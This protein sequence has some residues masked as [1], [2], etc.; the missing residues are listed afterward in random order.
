MI[1]QRTGKAFGHPLSA[2]SFRDAEATTL[3]VDDPD[4]VRVATTL[5][6]H[7]SLTTTA[8][9]YN[10]ARTATATRA[11]QKHVQVLRGRAKHEQPR[12]RLR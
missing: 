8:R 5:L 12:N 10:Q 9:H 7:G 3:A 11:Y 2:Y 4:N 1:T 6:G